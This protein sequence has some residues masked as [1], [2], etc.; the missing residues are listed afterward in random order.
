MI[1]QRK[2]TETRPA[3]VVITRAA[4]RFVSRAL[5]SVLV[6]IMPIAVVALTALALT[7]GFDGHSGS[8]LITV[9]DQAPFDQPL[10]VARLYYSSDYIQVVK[11]AKEQG[12]VAHLLAIIPETFIGA[13]AKG[14]LLDVDPGI[15]APESFRLVG[16]GLDGDVATAR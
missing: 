6:W 13:F 4:F 8:G 3:V 2:L 10:V 12:L 7:G 5:S 16:K 9:A 15:F 14:D 11:Q 1:R